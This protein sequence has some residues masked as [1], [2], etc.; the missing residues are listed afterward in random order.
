M[1]FVARGAHLQAFGLQPLFD[2]PGEVGVGIVDDEGAADGR[3]EPSDAD[4][5][6]LVAELDHPEPRVVEHEHAHR[7]ALVDRVL[8]GSG[9]PGSTIIPPIYS[10][11]HLDPADPVTYCTIRP[12]NLRPLV[13]CSCMSALRSSNGNVNQLVSP[14]RFFDI[15]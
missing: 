2:Q 9:T 14:S 11:L 12:A 13:P 7:Q 4:D 8:G 6:G 1:F 5:G 3:V 15:G 10:T